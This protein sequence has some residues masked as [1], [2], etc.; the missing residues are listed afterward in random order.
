MIA[1]YVVN[2]KLVIM[3]DTNEIKVLLL[4]RNRVWLGR[5]D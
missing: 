4:L 3:E 5:K 1:N 2:P